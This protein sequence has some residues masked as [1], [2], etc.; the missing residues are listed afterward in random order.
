MKL[1][2]HS[3][4]IAVVAVLPAVLA[5]CNSTVE[6][7]ASTPQEKTV[8]RSDLQAKPGYV[9]GTVSDTRGELLDNVSVRIFGNSS[10][11][12]KF[13]FSTPAKNGTYELRVP[14]GVYEAT[15]KVTVPYNGKTYTFDLAE[16][17]E[18]GYK[19]SEEGIVKNFV[20][21]LS[22]ERAKTDGGGVWGQNIGVRYTYHDGE[23]L[24]NRRLAPGEG[25]GEGEYVRP[26]A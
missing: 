23:E 26:L 20:W 16:I 6:G 2:S 17:G 8:A 1:I 10:K 24:L 12:D 4:R 18:G 14:D 13:E 25:L 5:A 11:G 19:H 9:R 7:Q 22:G 21:K 3:I 15:A